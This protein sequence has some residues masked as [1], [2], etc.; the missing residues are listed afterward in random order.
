MIDTEK[1][2]TL[3]KYRCLTQA[4][5]ADRAGLSREHYNRLE[6]WG[7]SSVT[8]STLSKLC[9]ALN[10]EIGEFWKEDEA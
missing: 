5:L 10:V 6:R 8:G 7:G 2:K 9:K 3:R 1:L 4:Q